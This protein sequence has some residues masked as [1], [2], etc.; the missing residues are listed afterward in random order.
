M[1]H[2]ATGLRVGAAALTLVVLAGCDQRDPAGEAIQAAKTTLATLTGGGRVVDTRQEKLRPALDEV[3]RLLTPHLDT[4][5]PGQASAAN[6]LFARAKASLATLKVEEANAAERASLNK[7]LEIRGK[8]DEWLVQQARAESLARFDPAQARAEISAK[9][10]L[11]ETQVAATTAARE[12]AES[13]VAA[14][15]QRADGLLVQAKALRAQAGTLR[16]RAAE[17]SATEGLALVQ[18]AT[19][20]GREADALDKE[21]S[22]V[23]ADALAGRP[24]VDDA[25]ALLVKFA[26]ERA[27]VRTA[28]TELDETTRATKGQAEAA[29]QQAQAAAAALVKLGEE[30]E[31]ARAADGAMAQAFDAAVKGF[32]DAVAAAKKSALT[33][34]SGEALSAAKLQVAGYQQALGDVLFVRGRGTQDH[35]ALLELLAAAKPALSG[36]AGFADRAKT[37]REQAAGVLS[38]AGEAY[39]A[40]KDGF[41]GAGGKE[42]ARARLDKLAEIVGQLSGKKAPPTPAEAPAP[43][44]AE[45]APAADAAAAPAEGDPIA[46]VKAAFLQQIADRKSGDVE[47]VLAHFVIA[48]EEQKA[49]VVAEMQ[50]GAAAADLDAACRERLNKP[51]AELVADAGP[52]GAMIASALAQMDPSVD[53]LTFTAVSPTE[54][55]VQGKGMPMALT[56]KLM[57]GVWRTHIPDMPPQLVQQ[58]K[59]MLPMVV[60]AFGAAAADV[61]AGT[62]TDG[63]GLVAAIMA[64][65][66]AGVGAAQGQP[67][68][69]K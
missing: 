27:Q 6:S 65:M 25:A 43:T 33:A 29:R 50:M 36:A 11:L 64:K 16:A 59:A 19:Q 69:N 38:E 10:A 49:L 66:A 18:Q 42:A 26:N 60:N 67:D 62:I 37:L 12:T 45:P 17:V 34:G 63:T 52:G 13:Q 46:A 4:R 55:Q 51:F 14:L 57:D 3:V 58:A 56:A 28:G 40:A 68:M 53:S 7:A 8:L 15:K 39:E 20:I 31:A 35:L 48:N 61:R 30:L 22:F 44:G 23:E 1:S 54:V 32:R 47:K 9:A 24:A 5:R 2:F 21:A 41:A